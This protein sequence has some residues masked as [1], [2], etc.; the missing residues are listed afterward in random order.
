MSIKSLTLATAIAMTASGAI[1]QEM[2]TVDSNYGP[3][4]VPVSPQ[5]VYVDGPWT[6]GNVVA[7]GVTP[8]AA[9]VYGE[10][11]IDY[12]SELTNGVDQLSYGDDGVSIETIATYDPDL[13]IIREWQVGAE[14]EHCGLATNVTSTFCDT[15]EKY[16]IEIVHDILRNIAS[17][18]NRSEEAEEII[19]TMNARIADRKSR[20]EA[21]ELDEKTVSVMRI[22]SDDYEFALPTAPMMIRS[23]GLT[24]PEGQYILYPEPDKFDWDQQEVSLENL[25]IV[26]ADYL[27]INV[28]LDN[29]GKLDALQKNPLYPM[30]P[31]VQNDQV[32]LVETGVWNSFDVLAMNTVLNQI[33]EFVII[34]AE[35]AN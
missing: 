13:I 22:R 18:L 28:D 7:L 2:R 19:A 20:V 5:R 21:L 15:G 35:Q 9:I 10:S 17:P 16:T 32:F 11:N 25:D 6:L 31:S 27:F 33:E 23:V 30:L 3:I 29:D 4:E 8:L 12:M 24:V 34:P 1:A 14:E 26:S